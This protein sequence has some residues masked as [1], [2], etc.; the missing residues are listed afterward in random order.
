METRNFARA[1]E[2]GG[3]GYLRGPSRSNRQRVGTQTARRAARGSNSPQAEAQSRV[4]ADQGA[5]ATTQYPGS[6]SNFIA[7]TLPGV[8]RYPDQPEEYIPIREADWKRLRTLVQNLV[9]PLPY[10]GQIGWAS[11]GVASS[12]VL[13]LIPWLAAYSQLP[14]RGQLHYAWVSPLLVIVSVAFTIIAGFCLIVNYVVRQRNAATAKTVL[15]EMDYIH[16]AETPQK[17]G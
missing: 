5:Q 6:A 4:S 17:S 3:G 10:L 2:P 1:R 16:I 11:V 12:T 15:A 14:S 7:A 9:H 13:T 8:I